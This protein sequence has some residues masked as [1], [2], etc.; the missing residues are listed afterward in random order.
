MSSLG[1]R[2][3]SGT[4][5]EGVFRFR[6]S[7]APRDI[8]GLSRGASRHVCWQLDLVGGSGHEA[9]RR[10]FSVFYPF[11]AVSNFISSVYLVAIVQSMIC[12]WVAPRPK[13]T[14]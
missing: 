6:A 3:G 9:R 14:S 2:E 10:P 11:S 1:A 8:V 7:L 12:H 4:T 13:V 5:F